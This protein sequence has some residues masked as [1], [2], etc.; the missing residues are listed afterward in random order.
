MEPMTAGYVDAWPAIAE[1]LRYLTALRPAAPVLSLY[2]DLN[3]TDFGTHRARRSAWTSLLNEARERVEQTDTDHEG[4]VSLRGDLERAAAFLEDYSPKGGRGVAILACSADDLFDTFTLPRSTRTR[5]VVDDSPYVT[6]LLHAADHRE[7]LIVLVDAHHA[8]FLHGNSDHVEEV[9]RVVDSVAGQHERSG[10]SDHQ[11]WVEHE[12][13]QHLDKTARE[14]DRQLRG[15]RL[16]RVLVGGPPE[17]A[18]RFEAA[19]SNHARERLAGRFDVDIEAAHPDDVRRAAL[20]CFDEDERRHERQRLDRLAERLGRGER[21]VAGP[22]DVLAMLEQARVETLLYDE[23]Y[24]AR[25]D[26]A[27]ERAV[28]DAIAQSAEVLALRHHPGE[29]AQHGDVA[30]LLRF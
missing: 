27:L 12:V 10:P 13:D 2:L 7:W 25:D 5:I 11:R 3:P 17:A 8:R 18:S 14:V 4:T 9:G 24:E 16:E 15:D 19:L 23:A 26:G 1:R 22:R 30:A 28:D 21:A 29:L 6:P 20:E